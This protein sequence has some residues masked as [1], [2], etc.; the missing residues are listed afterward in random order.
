MDPTQHNAFCNKCGKT[1]TWI[2]NKC[3]G[4]KG[5]FPCKHKCS[6]VDCR[7][8][9]KEM[10]ECSCHF[11]LELDEKCKRCEIPQKAKDDNLDNKEI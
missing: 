3:V 10:R 8:E 9:R 6:H 5:V 2:K 7:L 11:I 1:T 4:C